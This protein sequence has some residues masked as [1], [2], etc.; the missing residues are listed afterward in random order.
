MSMKR[1]ALLGALPAM[2]AFGLPVAKAQGSDPRLV[3]R[4]YNAA[5]VIKIHG[6]PGVQASI[7]FAEDEKIENVVVGDSDKRHITP[8]K[9][10]DPA[11]VPMAS[12]STFR[13]ALPEQTSASSSS[14][15]TLRGLYR[16]LPANPAPTCGQGR[17][18][19]CGSWPRR[20]S[21][22][23]RAAEADPSVRH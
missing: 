15:S 14:S 5:Q 9:P 19:R 12:S 11:P 2:L 20:I 6:R 4:V 7:A 23:R 3:S 16:T 21:I 8:N 1:L 13:R 18:S 22:F 10:G 17:A